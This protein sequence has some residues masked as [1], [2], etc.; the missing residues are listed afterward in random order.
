MNQFQ[1]IFW[2]IF[3]LLRVNFFLSLWKIFKK[4][5]H[6]IDLFDFTSFFWPGLFKIFWPTVIKENIKKKFFM[7]MFLFDFTSFFWPGLLKFTSQI[8]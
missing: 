7:K 1:G 4:K 5:I 2:D 3:H 8:L 6:E